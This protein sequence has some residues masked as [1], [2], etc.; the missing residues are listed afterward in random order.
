MK[1]L[2]K[3][4]LMILCITLLS[5]VQLFGQ[6]WSE[7]QKE[8][9]TAVENW[10]QAWADGD[11]NKIN[12]CVGEGYRIWNERNHAP[13]TMKEA[14]PWWKDWLQNNKNVLL[15][16][17]PV[18]IDIHDDIAIVFLSAQEVYKNKDGSEM[19]ERGK[20]TSIFQKIDGKW[21]IISETGFD[22]ISLTN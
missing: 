4:I 8:V 6:E 5:S 11:I 16:L 18:A 15:H 1:T 20:W 9:W 19:R 22:F 7:E 10:W 2:V 21:L 14:Q 13:F 17:K 12:S 3:S